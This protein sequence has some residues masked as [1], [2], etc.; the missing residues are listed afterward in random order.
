LTYL[1]LFQSQ[2]LLT[3]LGFSDG[4]GRLA[5]HRDALLTESC[6]AHDNVD[7]LN[8]VVSTDFDHRPGIEVAL[9][10]DGQRIDSHTRK[11]E[12]GLTGTVSRR[13]TEGLVVGA[14][15]YCG[16]RDA[17]VLLV[18]DGHSDRKGLGIVRTRC[19]H[20]PAEDHGRCEQQQQRS[21]GE[22]TDLRHAV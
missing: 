3:A 1:C 19:E 7:A 20:A 13:S 17:L 16:I 9:L 8:R 14:D 6:T 10:A 18:D 12:I 15:F 21:L 11:A 2:S 5:R 22:Y 4:V